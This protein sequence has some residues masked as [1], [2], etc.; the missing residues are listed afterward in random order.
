[1]AAAPS[2]Q[3]TM[4]RR[5]SPERLTSRDT[6]R[7]NL[8]VLSAAGVRIALDDYGVGS[9]LEFVQYTVDASEATIADNLH[10]LAS[11]YCNDAET[12]PLV[13]QYE[14][15]TSGAVERKISRTADVR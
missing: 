10:E 8:E 9:R 15:G 1:M 11:K 12:E 6:V 2:S 14:G 13:C 7:D 5:V 3:L 4:S